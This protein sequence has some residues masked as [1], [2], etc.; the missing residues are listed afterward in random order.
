MTAETTNVHFARR[1]ARMAT[2]IPA[3]AL[4]GLLRLIYGPVKSIAMTQDQD[5]MLLSKREVLHAK[6]DQ[7]RRQHKPTR[8]L[9]KEAYLI[10]HE[11]LARGGKV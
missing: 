6:I 10:T 9:V 3:R 4:R 5:A 7:A 11:I 1:G 2:G 8:H